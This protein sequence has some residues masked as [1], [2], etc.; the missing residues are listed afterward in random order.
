MTSVWFS[1]PPDVDV[2]GEQE[3]CKTRDC[4]HWAFLIH[5]LVDA[6]L[7]PAFTEEDEI[8]GVPRLRFYRSGNEGMVYRM[9]GNPKRPQVLIVGQVWSLD[10]ERTLIEEAQRRDKLAG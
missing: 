5:R 8:M 4:G 1:H 6:E 3:Q 10:D 2:A 7:D 9:V